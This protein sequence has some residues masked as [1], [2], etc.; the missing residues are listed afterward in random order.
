MDTSRRPRRGR[1]LH[2][3]SLRGRPDRAL[4][5][6]QSRRPRRTDPTA[7][8]PESA[9]R[10]KQSS[11]ATSVMNTRMPRRDAQPAFFFTDTSQDTACA[12]ERFTSRATRSAT[13]SS[14]SSVTARSHLARARPHLQAVENARRLQV[15]RQQRGLAA[16]STSSRERGATP[17]RH[18]LEAPGERVK[19]R[20]I[21]F[22]MAWTPAPIA[23]STRL[24][25][26]CAC[27]FFG[28]VAARHWRNPLPCLA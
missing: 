10:M 27:A 25:G 1:L 18:G 11:L 23:D 3:P 26:S 6:A 21:S 24:S 14:P 9:T 13:A 2:N 16:R 28:P 5:S 17:G 19:E 12:S 7:S 20:S 8:V 4:P 15:H 22:A